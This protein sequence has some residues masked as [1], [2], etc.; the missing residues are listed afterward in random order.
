M[1]VTKKKI[2][3][4]NDYRIQ[5]V[6]SLLCGCL[7]KWF[8]LSALALMF[9]L[10]QGQQQAQWLDHM[11]ISLPNNAFLLILTQTHPPFLVTHL[12]VTSM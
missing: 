3:D 9:C 5:A 4:D 12:T 8:E 1:V 6:T 2:D 7:W 11:H 10:I